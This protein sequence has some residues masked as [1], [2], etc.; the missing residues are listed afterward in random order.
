MYIMKH[1][2]HILT[3]SC[4]LLSL[5]S[6]GAFLEGLAMGTGTLSNSM[7]YGNSYSS[8]LSTTPLAESR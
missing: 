5:T 4:I 7:T 3:V 8:C 2:A 6:C 1:I